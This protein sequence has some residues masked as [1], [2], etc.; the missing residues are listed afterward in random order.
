MK[1][2]TQFRADHRD[3]TI[4]NAQCVDGIRGYLVEVLGCPSRLESFNWIKAGNAVDFYNNAN[5]LHFTKIPNSPSA[6]PRAGDIIVA[7]HRSR[8]RDGVMRDYGHVFIFTQGDVHYLRGYGQNWTR[9]HACE[10]EYHP[11]YE[12]NADDFHVIGWLR[13]KAKFTL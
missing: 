2:F 12:S 8:G 6:V 4:P 9:Y 13:P 1:S 10:Y 11:H 5:T 3:R 7:H